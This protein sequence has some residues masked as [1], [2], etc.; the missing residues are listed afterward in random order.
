MRRMTISL[1]A[2]G[3]LVL[4]AACS[5][6]GDTGG[7]G[8]GGTAGAGGNANGGSGEL[9][10]V[11]VGVLPI[12][13]TAAIWLGVEEGIFED[14]GLDV[15]LELAQGGAAVVP[16]VVS[17]DYQ[18][19]FS[20]VASLL[21]AN[22]QGLPLKIVAPGN[23]TTGD[24]ES[25][26]GAVLAMPDSGIESPADLAGK[27]VAVNTLNNIGDVTVSEVVEQAGGDP[28]Q[29]SF[30]EMGFPDMPAALA[31]GQVDAA[32]ILEPFRTI[33]MDQG[34]EVVTHNFA[35]VD[36]EMMIAAYFT[37]A[38][39]AE[40]DP[41]IVESFTAAMEESLTFA[42]ENP[43]AARAILSTY[44]E[45]DPAVQEKMVMPRFSPDVNADSVQTLADLALKYGLVSED[46]DVDALL[47]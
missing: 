45:I 16:A 24:P 29:I 33:A 42:E 31:G 21:V 15:E 37:T 20:N 4:L 22:S 44:T 35:D 26:I 27:S 36:P 32:W 47:P 34:A 38:T 10:P 39:Y 11:T 3:S 6:G 30:V 43:D 7:G 23:F 18:F 8:D 13:D 46:V 17:G 40:S 2:A 1:A 12:V 25:D 28:E 5:G 41:E 14:H 9:T 19:G